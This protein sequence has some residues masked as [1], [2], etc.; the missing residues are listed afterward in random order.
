MVIELGERWN[1]RLAVERTARQRGRH[2]GATDRIEQCEVADECRDKCAMENVARPQRA[3]HLDGIGRAIAI[4]ATA[5][6]RSALGPQRYDDVPGAGRAGG[7]HR[8]LEVA[9]ES[10]DQL[11]PGWR[12]EIDAG[13]IP[14]AEGDAPIDADAALK[15][16]RADDLAGGAESFGVEMKPARLRLQRRRVVEQRR[17]LRDDGPG[18]AGAAGDVDAERCRGPGPPRDEAGIDAEILPAGD[19]V[20]AGR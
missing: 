3:D 8:A 20:V 9:A 2:A 13:Q 14:R 1:R 11:L 6:D 4:I 19:E 12:V 18:F 10:F 7:R 15:P 5:Q 16:A 17:R